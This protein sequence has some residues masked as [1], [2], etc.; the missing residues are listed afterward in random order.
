MGKEPVTTPI[1]IIA[2]RAIIEVTPTASKLAKGSWVLR[3]ILNPLHTKSRNRKITR[4]PPKKPSSS[5]NT[6][7]IKSVCCSGR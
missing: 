5:P 2:C 3:A 4:A 7:K 1:L 6:A